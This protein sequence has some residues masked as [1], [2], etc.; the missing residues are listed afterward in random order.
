MFLSLMNIEDEQ[1]RYILP[2]SAAYFLNSLNE[3]CLQREHYMRYIF[4]C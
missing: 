2:Y 1:E 3:R 4:P